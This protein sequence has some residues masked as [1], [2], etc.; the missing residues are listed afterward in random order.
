MMQVESAAPQ[1]EVE[2]NSDLEPENQ[3]D[4]DVK[5]PLHNAWTL[6]YDHELQSGKRPANWGSNLQEV[7]TFSTV[8]DFWRM[9]NNLPA[10]SALQQGCG[11]NLFKKGIEPKWEDKKIQ[12]VENGLLY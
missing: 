5:H 11:F 9:F 10:P 1:K 8:E 12:Q 3:S 4:D 7:Y 2:E 6:W